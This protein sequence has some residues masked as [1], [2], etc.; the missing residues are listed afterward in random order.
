MAVS[1]ITSGGGTLTAAIGTEHVLVSTTTAGVYQLVVDTRNMVNGDVLE[2]RCYLA[3]LSGESLYLTR[4]QRY[5]NTQG[6]GAADT[7]GDG[8]V[9]VFSIP[10][11]SPFG[12]RFSLKQTL[13]TGRSYIWSVWQQ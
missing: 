6:D 11:T 7:G 10:F 1:E 5:R 4:I 12:I 3:V 13:G 8:E 9:I 2:L